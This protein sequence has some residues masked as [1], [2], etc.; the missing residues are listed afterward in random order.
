MTLIS[1]QPRL[2]TVFGGSGFIGRHI[3][4]ALAAAGYRVRVAV[5]RPDL[6]FHLQPLGGV[7]QIVPVQAN[8][9]FADSVRAAV[10]GADAV[11]NAVGVLRAA[12]AQTAAAVNADGARRIAEAARAAG[13]DRF[14]HLS[15]I[16]ADATS[17]V[18]YAR[19]KAEGEAAVL[20]AVPDAV[21]L[22]PSVVFGPE[23]HFFNLFAGLASLTPLLPLIGGGT[24]RLQP[25]YVEDVAAAVARAVAG[26]ARPGTVYEL[27][28]P[29]VMTLADCMALAARES[30]RKA[31]FVKVSA[32]LARALARATAWVPGSPL[33]A[34]EVDMLATD[35]VVSPAAI[36]DGRDLPGLG[37][38][39]R[40]VAAIVPGYLYRFLPHGQYDRVGHGA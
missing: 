35:N 9:R 32:G 24:T 4:R 14:V 2:V 28:G 3:V 22:R 12:G 16:G 39:P 29:D 40:A 1:Q 5:R 19:S 17:T 15:A 33:A 27:G 23:D 10:A 13:I 31:R 6:A 34:D 36:A 18:A 37:L 8:L 11:V 26:A 7:G 25:V 30:G 20:A 21:I 38:P